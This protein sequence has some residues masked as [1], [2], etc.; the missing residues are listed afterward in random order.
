MHYG[1]Q[2]GYTMKLI[3][4][5]HRDGDNVEVSVQPTFLAETH[6]LASVM[7]NIMLSMFMEKRLEKRCFM[8]REQ[9][10][11]QQRQLLYRI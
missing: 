2:L 11:C 10:A 3:G 4:L 7:M 5:A 9:E 8:D 1:K 6:P